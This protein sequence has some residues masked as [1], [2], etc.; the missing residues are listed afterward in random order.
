MKR[1]CCLGDSNT[2]GYDPRSWL[3]G[4]YPPE[5]R[6]TALLAREGRRL[7]DCGQNGRS[8]PRE[9][10]RLYLPGM[11]AGEPPDALLIM[12]GSNDLLQGA[13]AE[14]VG[15]RM[16]ALLDRLSAALPETCL[17]LIAP[18]PMVW[19]DWAADEGLLRESVRLAAVYRALAQTRGLPFADSGAWG[20]A[21][22]HD[23]VHFTP[24]GHRAF[25]RGLDTLLESLGL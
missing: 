23:G 15:R 21:L 16:A 4:R 7:I 24:E 14:T 8:I 3:G 13:D 18:P 22:S 20:I 9:G 6:W 25:A 17:L 2:Y 10:E 19:G 11:E 1:I 12:L 5:Q